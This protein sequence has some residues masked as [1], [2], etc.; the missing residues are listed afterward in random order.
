MEYSMENYISQVIYLP[1]VW[2]TRDTVVCRGQTLDTQNHQALFSLL[3]TRWGGDGIHTFALPDLRPWT[4][5][6]PDYG[7]HVRREWHDDELVPH[8]VVEGIYPSRE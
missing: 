5:T 4:D 6:G 2:N 1:F 7:K 8:M 3:G